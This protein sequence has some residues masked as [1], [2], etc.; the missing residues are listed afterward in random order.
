[1][2]KVGNENFNY[3]SELLHW[4]QY[5]ILFNEFFISFLQQNHII[6]NDV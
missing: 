4:L 5:I 1:M 2:A 3:K 6:N